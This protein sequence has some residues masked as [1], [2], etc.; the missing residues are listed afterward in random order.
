MSRKSL[1]Q[2]SPASKQEGLRDQ[3]RS[4]VDAELLS[5]IE[6]KLDMATRLLKIQSEIG[7]WPNSPRKV[8]LSN[9]IGTWWNKGNDEELQEVLSSVCCK[10][11]SQHLGIPRDFLNLSRDSLHSAWSDDDN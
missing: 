7:R 2:D 5:Y 1:F 10:K 4:T 6:S 3:P 11:E 8:Y 9:L